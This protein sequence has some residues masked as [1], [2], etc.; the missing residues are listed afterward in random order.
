MCTQR[1]YKP[2]NSSFLF[3]LFALT[4][5]ALAVF[6]HYLACICQVE[7]FRH[8]LSYLVTPSILPIV[9]HSH[10]CEAPHPWSIFPW[11]IS[12]CHWMSPVVVWLTMSQLQVNGVSTQESSPSPFPPNHAFTA[13]SPPGTLPLLKKAPSDWRPCG[14]CLALNLTTVSDQYHVP[15]LQDFTS[16]LWGA[17]QSSAS[18]PLQGIPSD[19]CGTS[20]HPQDGRDHTLQVVRDHPPRPSNASLTRFFVVFRSATH[21][22]M[23]AWLPAR[24]CLNTSATYAKSSAICKTTLSTSVHPSVSWM[25]HPWCF[26]VI[27]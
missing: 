2:C 24:A 4:L 1:T 17:M 5:Y 15:H 8:V 9:V 3:L 21:P 25:L 10:G 6:I 22:W 27:K 20:G 19:P 14:D 18:W 23:I 7:C 12:N 11:D 26:L 16:L 13:H